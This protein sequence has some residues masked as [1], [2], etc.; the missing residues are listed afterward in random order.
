MS[1]PFNTRT[2][3]LP[4]IEINRELQSRQIN[5]MLDT[6][7]FGHS[8]GPGRPSKGPACVRGSARHYPQQ[9]RDL[10]GLCVRCRFQPQHAVWRRERPDQ[11]PVRR[12]AH[13][14]DERGELCP[15]GHDAA[16]VAPADLA[17]AYSLPKAASGAGSAACCRPRSRRIMC[18]ILLPH[19]IA[20]AS[21][22][23][24]QFEGQPSVDLSDA[25]QMA[26]LNAVLRALFSMPDQEERDRLGNLVRQYVTGPG[27]PGIS[28]VLPHPKRRLPS[29]WAGGAPSRSA[30]SRLSMR[31]SPPAGAHRAMR[32][33]ATCSIS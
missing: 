30:G 16:N 6:T 1:N 23:V 4:H 5:P 28:T 26:A 11:R 20:A 25:Y 32:T 17:G 7:T 15:P 10:A 9:P 13:V 33:N 3:T 24:H 2:L 21:D 31:S 8:A 12:S 19:F 14:G 27:R 22:L 29:R 18:N